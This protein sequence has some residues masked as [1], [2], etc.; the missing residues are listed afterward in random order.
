MAV[1][2]P[3][4]SGYQAYKKNK[5]EQASPH[6]L[7]LMLYDGALR[8]CKRALQSIEEKN[9]KETNESLKKAQDIIYELIA[10]VN[11]EQGG[12]V[13]HNLK[14]LYL[15]MIDRLVHA[16]IKKDAEPVAE[17]IELLSEIRTAWEQ[18]GRG[19]QPAYGQHI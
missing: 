19:V 14:R 18:I 5:Y 6:K 1:S 3:Y 2:I 13:A 10:A 15:Y 12:E 17:V 7:I 9:V 11:E 4:Q 8:Y 16:N